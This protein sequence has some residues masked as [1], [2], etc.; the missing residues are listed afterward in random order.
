[1]KT[2]TID[3]PIIKELIKMLRKIHEER[4]Y[5]L[6]SETTLKHLLYK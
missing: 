4:V 3:K 6:L 2:N 5:L 1:M